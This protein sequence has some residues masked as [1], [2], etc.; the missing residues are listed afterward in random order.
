[1]NT[2][3]QQPG[4][5][6]SGSKLSRARRI[7]DP[8][9]SREDWPRFAS[10]GEKVR[11]ICVLDCETTGL[12]PAKHQIIELCAAIV[13]VNEAGFVLAVQ[14]VMTGLVDPGHPLSS[15]IVKLTGLTDADLAGGSIASE[16][17]IALLE[18]CDG[19]VAF[20][21]QF[22]RPF[23]E[24][25]IGSHVPV[26]WGCAMAD[27]PWR[28]LGF[29]PG[30]QGYLLMQTGY[31]MPSAHRAKDDVLAL[32]QVLD[33]ECADGET[34]MAK[35]LAA[36]DDP[37]WRFEASTAAYGYKDDLWDKRYRFAPGRTQKLWHKHVRKADFREEYGWYRQTIGKRPVVVPLPATERYRADNTWEP[38]RPKVTTPD[39]LK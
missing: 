28:G 16:G 34:I 38:T 2:S 19:V 22:D 12:N 37:A 15:E 26:P 35:V 9:R 1:M 30:Q 27:V 23:V 7:L 24:K 14:S 8:V 39:W 3:Q 21:A 20:N 18:Y 25:L 36:M 4:T 31:F 29:E 32:I 5:S 10:E 11:R 13:L 17:L 6:G 33:H